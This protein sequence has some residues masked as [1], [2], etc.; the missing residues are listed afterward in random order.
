MKTKYVLHGGFNKERGPVHMNDEFFAEILR[1]APKELNTLLVYF[2]EREEIIPERIEQD[3]GQFLKNS[4]GK[5][6]TFRVTTEVTFEQ[7]CAWA[8][9]IYLHGGKTVKLMEA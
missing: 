3:K 6:I 7:D 9:A 5:E 2:A 4:A 8:N 1:D